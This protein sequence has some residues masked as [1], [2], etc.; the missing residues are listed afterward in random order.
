MRIMLFISVCLIWGTTWLAMA[1]AGESIPSLAA[2]ALRFMVMSPILMVLARKSRVPLL[3]PRDKWHYM[4]VIA[5]FYFAIPFWFMIEGEKYI[6]SGLASIIFSYMPITIMLLSYLMARQR[7]TLRQVVPLLVTLASLAGII[8]IESGISGSHYLVGI[9][10]LSG[11][12]LLHGCVYLLKQYRFEQINVLTFSAIPSGMAS[13]LL[14]LA[15][16]AMEQAV[17]ADITLPSLL[18]VLY[19]GSVAGVGGIVAYFKLN[20]LVTPFKASL[21]FLVFPVIAVALEAMVTGRMLSPLSL[22]FTL[23]L[24]CGIYLLIKPEPMSCDASEVEVQRR[25]G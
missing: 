25:A 8:A 21:C 15:S 18:A 7:F 1:I 2:T 12:V 17:V 24:A 3:F 14:L 22:L 6:S 23:P 20:A 13:I 4:P 19:L 16:L 9:A 11:A 10:L 5:I